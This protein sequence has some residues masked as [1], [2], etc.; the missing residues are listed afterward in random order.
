MMGIYMVVGS[1]LIERTE[2]NMRGRV[3]D[4]GSLLTRTDTGGADEDRTS[5]TS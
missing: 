2:T 1:W 4:R 3:D 5:F